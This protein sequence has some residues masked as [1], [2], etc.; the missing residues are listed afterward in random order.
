VCGHLGL[1]ADEEDIAQDTMLKLHSPQTLARMSRAG[2]PKA[3]LYVMVRNEAVERLRRRTREK[4]VTG[5]FSLDDVASRADSDS[6]FE[7]RGLLAI[8]REMRR[9]P[10]KDR[11]LLRLRFWKGLSIREI[12]RVRQAPYSRTAVQLFRVLRRLRKSLDQAHME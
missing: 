6:T 4:T 2:S 9:L 7:T 10:I 12:A 11:E 5:R 8:R 3:Y 1:T